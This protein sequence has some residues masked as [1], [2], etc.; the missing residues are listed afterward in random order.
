M[1]A[2]AT[3]GKGLLGTLGPI[4]LGIAAVIAVV[5][6]LVKAFEAIKNSTPEAKLSRLKEETEKAKTSFDDLTNSI[7]ETKTALDNL[8]SSYDKIRSLKEGTAEW[9]EEIAKTNT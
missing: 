8:E 9:R 5:Y 4:A 1:T 7:N 3:A 6:L 2:A